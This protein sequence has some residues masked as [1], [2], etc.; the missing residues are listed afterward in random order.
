MG[1]PRHG[2]IRG[3]AAG[4]SQRAREAT[5]V[6]C[7]VMVAPMAAIPGPASDR[8]CTPA[9]GQSDTEGA[10]DGRKSRVDRLESPVLGVSRVREHTCPAAR[11]RTWRRRRRVSSPRAR[12]SRIA[13]DAPCQVTFCDRRQ[14]VASAEVP[15]TR[16]AAEVRTRS[17]PRPI[18]GRQT[19]LRS[20]RAPAIPRRAWP[21]RCEDAQYPCGPCRCRGARCR[22]GRRTR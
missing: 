15:G 9:A 14:R 6:P 19:M 2:R 16:S 8:S 4:V 12:C 17:G 5:A 21:R 10:Y 3:P 1:V 20:K 7:P 13:R 22:S 18:A 11:N